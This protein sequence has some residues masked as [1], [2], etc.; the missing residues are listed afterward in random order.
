[1]QYYL[2][3]LTEDVTIGMDTLDKENLQ[4]VQAVEKMGLKVA[5][6]LFEK[7]VLSGDFELVD[8]EER[9]LN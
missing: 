6:L 8:T 4:N 2:V 7:A 9:I 3:H 1:M 5:T